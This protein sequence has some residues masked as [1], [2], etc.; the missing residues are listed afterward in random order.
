MNKLEE[1][2]Y[3]QDTLTISKKL[4]GKNLVHIVDNVPRIGKIVETEAYIGPI[5]KACHAYNYKRTPRTEP[6]F[7]NGGISY[8]YLIYGMYHCM[9]IVT[10]KENM[11]CAVLIR[12]LEPISGLNEM[13]LDR[14]KASYDSLNKTQIKN[15]ANGPGK[16][17][18]AMNITKNENKINLLSNNFYICDNEDILDDNIVISKRINIDYADEA[19]EFLWRFYIKDNKFISKK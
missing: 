11:P 7:S 2:F 14:Y 19:K 15:I 12:A 10:E 5:D 8:V 18:I 9:N 16:L 13:A 1:S 3:L 6:L 4:L 17:C